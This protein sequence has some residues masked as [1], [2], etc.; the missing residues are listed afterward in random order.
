LKL[1]SRS[2]FS[3]HNSPVL[4]WSLKLIKR[5]SNTSNLFSWQHPKLEIS[6]FSL[7]YPCSPESWVRGWQGSRGRL[8]H[9]PLKP[10]SA[11]KVH[12]R[13][14][15]QNLPQSHATPQALSS[16]PPPPWPAQACPASHLAPQHRP[17]LSHLQPLQRLLP[18]PQ[19]PLLLT[20]PPLRQFLL[21]LRRRETLI[22]QQAAARRRQVLAIPC[23]TSSL[24]QRRQ[25][26]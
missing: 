23:R 18:S 13:P 22:Q 1:A 26:G 14:R 21:P 2:L 11:L 3:A 10:L 12:Q 9:R 4:P 5:R 19:T 7:P 15:A 20:P 6:L 8:A 17:G 16:P 25:R 24:T